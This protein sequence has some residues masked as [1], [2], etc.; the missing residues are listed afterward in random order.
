MSLATI[1]SIVSTVLGLL[2]WFVSY[3][4]QQK[5]IEIGESR[6]IQKSLEE[7]D[8]VVKDAQ[9]ARQTV[10]DKLARDPDSILRDD[11]GFKRPD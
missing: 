1:L 6:A 10:R 3:T 11:D 4:E 5:W 2:K 9:T 8:Q 7:A